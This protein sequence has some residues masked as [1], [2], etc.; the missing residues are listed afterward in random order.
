MRSA[1]ELS[2]EIRR[3]KKAMLSDPETVDL[4]GIPE[5]AT[6]E[7]NMDTEAYTDE[8]GLD[9]NKP[10]DHMEDPTPSAHQE[11]ME[12]SAHRKM[13]MDDEHDE[14][15]ENPETDYAAGGMVGGRGAVAGGEPPAKTPLMKVTGLAEGGELE[16][17]HMKRKA[18]LAKAMGRMR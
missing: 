18:R 12:D 7:A 13:H 11:L 8:L 17:A 6:D 9:H 3:K 4:S 1:K 16:D 14:N 10:K 2:L 5:D 15:S